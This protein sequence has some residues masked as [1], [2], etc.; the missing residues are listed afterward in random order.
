MVYSPPI[1]GSIEPNDVF[2]RL[3]LLAEHPPARL[4]PGKVENKS[5]EPPLPGSVVFRCYRFLRFRSRSR[6]WAM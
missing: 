5:N 4:L 2:G 6:R 3:T 1:G